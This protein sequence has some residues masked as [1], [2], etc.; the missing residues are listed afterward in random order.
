MDTLQESQPGPS[1]TAGN[2]AG[3]QTKNVLDYQEKSEPLGISEITSSVCLE[4]IL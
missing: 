4:V 2:H 1:A 3:F